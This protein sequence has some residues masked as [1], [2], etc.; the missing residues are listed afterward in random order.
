MN[1]QPAGKILY[2]SF[3]VMLVLSACGGGAAQT[4][5]AEAVVVDT[6]TP[7]ATSTPADTPTPKP[8][9]TATET[10]LP[11]ATATPNMT[12]TR[13][14]EITPAAEGKGNVAGLVLWNNEPVPQAAVWLCERFEGD[15]LGLYQY[16]ANTDEN[17]YFIFKNV[18]PGKYLVAINSFSTGWFVFY[19]DSD[20]NREQEVS[21]GGN[22]ILN[23][24]NIWKFNLVATLPKYGKDY[25]QTN[26]TFTWE[27]YPD[28]AYYLFSIYDEHYDTVLE[29]VRVD[30]TEYTLEGATLVTCN[31]YWTVDAY[32]ANDVKISATRAPRSTLMY[33]INH[34]VP[35]TC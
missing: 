20:G 9:V 2:V 22:L 16:R 8:T 35:G 33:F 5:S 29:D 28:A 12:A 11:T 18:T 26:P 31:Y 30:G 27:P 25:S 6:S 34:S 4:E 23:P 10:P 15:C 32:N 24:W 21:S 7:A 1:I 19:F 3:I 14:P 17:G 13:L